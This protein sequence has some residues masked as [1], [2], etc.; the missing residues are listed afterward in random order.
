[1]DVRVPFEAIDIVLV[2]VVRGM[3]INSQVFHLHEVT[4]GIENVSTTL[5]SSDKMPL[6]AVLRLPRLSDFRR[7]SDIRGG[8]CDVPG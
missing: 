8:G 5:A 3:Y 2:N 1:M 4:M 7:P 6:V